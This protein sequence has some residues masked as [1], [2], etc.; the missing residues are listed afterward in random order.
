[1]PS[2]G[3]RH[4]T[5]LWAGACDAGRNAQRPDRSYSAATPLLRS[6]ARSDLVDAQR[7][8]WPGRCDEHP[9]AWHRRSKPSMRW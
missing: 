6:A 3:G 7:Q 5:P 9:R 4:P 1:V 8:K 2:G